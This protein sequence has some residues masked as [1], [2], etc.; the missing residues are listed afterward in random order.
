MIDAVQV[1][2]LLVIVTLAVLLLILGVQV[3][4][5][6]REIRKTVMKANQ[7]LDDT[8]AITRSV[9]GPITSVASLVEGVS[10][11]AVV[12]KAVKVLLNIFMKQ[13]EGDNARTK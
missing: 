12:G 7:V 4:F 10:T 8:G 9:T 13:E 6:L 3:F 5:I 1:I 11:G 2:L